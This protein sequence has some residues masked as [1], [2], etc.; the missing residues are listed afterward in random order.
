MLSRVL[1]VIREQIFARLFGAGLY[2]DALVV[3]FRIPNMLRDLFAEGALSAAFIPALGRAR[4]RGGDEEVAALSRAV[5][6]AVILIV[7]SLTILGILLT[8]TLVDA[9]A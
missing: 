7:G 3:A 9:I 4:E 2:A 5:L 8:P 1:G 6:S